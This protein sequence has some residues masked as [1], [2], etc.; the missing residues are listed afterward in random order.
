VNAIVGTLVILVALLSVLVVGLLR[1]HAEIVR[2]LHDLGVNLD[3]DAPDGTFRAA[4]PS[5]A[6][7][8]R[9]TVSDVGPDATLEGVA[10]PTSGRLVVAHDLA[11][12]TPD[13][14]AAVV[15]VSGR[16]GLTLVAFLSTGC[17]TCA[18]FWSAF[19]TPPTLGGETVRLVIVT[20]SPAAE[21]PSSVAELA[22]EHGLVVMSD[23]AFDDHGVAAAPYFV[24][25][26]GADG[27]VVG[28]GSAAGW[29][30]LKALLQRAAADAGWVADR[31]SRRDLLNAGSRQRQVDQALAEAGIY[32]GDPS[33][34][35][36]S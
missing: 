1:S 6:A 4:S 14:G 19:R 21:S 36:E 5:V 8:R 23:E 10:L 7:S 25:V 9:P 3:P 24:L 2:A 20:R 33:L 11:G 30:Q 18:D 13:G 29:V 15:S 12:A 31:R 34:T 17:G 22:P 28:E 35:A 16:P 27:S 32:P 26:D